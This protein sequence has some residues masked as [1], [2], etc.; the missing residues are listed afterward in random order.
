MSDEIANGRQNSASS[1]QRDEIIAQLLALI[2][3]ALP[4]SSG[5]D[6]AHVP[7]LEMGANSLVLLEF[8]RT[9]ESIWGVTIQLPQFF[10]K[11]R[12]VLFGNRSVQFV[13]NC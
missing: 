1:A 4:A 10:E 13:H 12:L 2:A 9:V 3:E 6:A 11:D 8:Q 5:A 7:F